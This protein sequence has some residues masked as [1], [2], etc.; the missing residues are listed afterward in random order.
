M[1]S[2]PRRTRRPST[3]TGTSC[4]I[5]P[6]AAC[7]CRSS[8]RPMGRRWSTARSSCA[9]TPTRAA[10]RRGISSTGCRSRPERYSEILRTIVKEAGAEESAAGKALLAHRLPPQGAAPSQPQG[11]ARPSRR[12]CRRFAGGAE[13]IE[14]GLVRLSRRARTVPAQTLALHHLLE[15][16]HYRLGH[17]RLASSDINYRRFFDVN[18]LAGLRIEDAGTFEAIHRLVQTAD[19]GGKAAGPAARPHRRA[20]RSRAI[21][22][23]PAPH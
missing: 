2:R 5:A 20:A 22:P 9:T 3:S 15:R 16:Q 21:F 14:R 23:A 18:T 11:S 8:A 6:A 12:S 17:W 19:R 13:I 10:F 7:C 1:G 4:P